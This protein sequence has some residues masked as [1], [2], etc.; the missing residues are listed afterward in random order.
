AGVVDAA[1]ALGRGAGAGGGPALGGALGVGGAVGGRA[2]AEVVHVAQA[3]RGAAHGGRRLEVVG[4]AVV[5]DAVAALGRVAG[6]GGGPALGGAL[7][8]GGAVSGRARA[9]VVHVAH[10]GRRAA[11]GGHGLEVVRWTVVVGAVAALGDVA[12]AG[13]GTAHGRALG[14]GGAVRGRAR[15]EVVC[16]AHVRRRAAQ[17]AGGLEVIGRTVVVHAIAAL[18]VVAGTGGGPALGRALGVGG[19]VGG[20]ARAEVVY[21]AHP[22]RGAA[23]GG[24]GR[25]VVG[26]AVVMDAIAAFG[27]VAGTGG[28]PA[29]GRALGVGRAVGGRARAEVVHVAHPRRGAA[30]GGRGREVVGGAV[31]VDAIAALGHVAHARHGPAHRCALLIRGAEVGL[32]VAHL[33]QIAV[34]AGGA[35]RDTPWRRREGAEAVGA[36][37]GGAGV[38]VAALGR[39]G[40]LLGDDA[41]GRIRVRLLRRVRAGIEEIRNPRAAEVAEVD[42]ARGHRVGAAVEGSRVAHHRGSARRTAGWQL[43]RIGAAVGS[44]VRAAESTNRIQG[45]RVALHRDAERE[46]G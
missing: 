20:R 12:D 30:Q 4:G 16:V 9:E 11:H 5:V 32:A 8:V 6:A 15:A 45:C 34:A 10:A 43:H 40:A 18:G 26:G 31:V 42:G 14:I 19:A 17:G 38:V 27:V 2:R 13:R 3:G 36:G 41:V 28:G 7:G 33:G 44:V 29:L 21:V 22:R 35:A 23:Q 24:R 1:A 39:G 37:V 25:E 46:V